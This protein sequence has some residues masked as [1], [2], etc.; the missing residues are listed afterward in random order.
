MGNAKKG[1]NKTG[2]DKVAAQKRRASIPS[3]PCFES[4]WTATKI[5]ASGKCTNVVVWSPSLPRS[6]PK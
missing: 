5:V 1:H 4:L 3:W 6:E 2:R